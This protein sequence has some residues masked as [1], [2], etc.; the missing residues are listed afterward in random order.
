MANFLAT[1]LIQGKLAWSTL[2]NSVTYAKY[3]DSVLAVLETRGYVIDSN[4]NCVKSAQLHHLLAQSN[5][6]I[7]KLLNIGILYSVKIIIYERTNI[8]FMSME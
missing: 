4:G 6:L 1:R 7:V 3:C 5:M 2:E 8:S